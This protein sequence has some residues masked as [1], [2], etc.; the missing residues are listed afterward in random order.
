MELFEY[1]KFLKEL[2]DFYERKEPKPGTAELWFEKVAKI[3]GEPLKWIAK[4]IENDNDS[5]PRNLPTAICAA[6]REWQQANPSKIAHKRHEDCPDCQ[7]GLIW[8][9]QAKQG[10]RYTYVFAC[11]RC[12]QCT[13][14]QY[15]QALRVE[16]MADYDV[17]PK[18]G[19]PALTMKKYSNV[20]DMAAHIGRVNA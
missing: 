10:I 9:R 16:L 4:K 6:Y 2:S 19:D 7:D 1:N 20:I 13:A 8:A 17:I 5:F 11:A 18:A 15:P 14:S 12:Q 3:P